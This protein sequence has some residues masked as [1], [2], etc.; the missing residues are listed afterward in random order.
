MKLKE[1]PVSF[2]HTLKLLSISVE[3]LNTSSKT[4]PVIVSLTTI[5]SRLDTVH[6]TLRSVMNQTVQP[7][8]IILWITE[9]DQ[10]KIPN[11]LLKLSGG[12]LE[13]KSTPRTSSHKKLLPTLALFPEKVIVTC[14][15]DLIYE[16]QWLEK[17]YATHLQFPNDI[18]CNKAR[19]IA[20]DDNNQ[21]LDYKLWHYSHNKNSIRNLAIG[22]GGILYPPHSL[23][24]QVTNYDLALELAPKSDDLWFK[25]MALLNKTTVR[26]SENPS[27]FF[28]PIP[29][30]QKISLKKIN[31]VKNYNVEQWE[32]LVHYFKINTNAF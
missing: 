30:T 17:L 1:Y 9:A 29:G 8:K 23:N 4:I 28:V 24:E 22:E 16:S 27:T 6:I 10:N 26:I 31:V 7:E 18:I 32:K 5:A 21:A 3:N 20:L 15:D 2:Y 13:I 11:S 12:L 19:A 25:A 14:D